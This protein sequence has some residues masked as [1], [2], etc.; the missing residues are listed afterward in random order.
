MATGYNYSKS[1]ASRDWE[2]R[3]LKTS[4]GAE[5]LD[6]D[7][8]MGGC[9]RRCREGGKAECEHSQTTSERARSGGVRDAAREGGGGPVNWWWRL[10]PLCN[11]RDCDRG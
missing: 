9:I 10:R 2:I 3:W 8:D 5:S 11:W 6:G 7:L 1:L 4:V